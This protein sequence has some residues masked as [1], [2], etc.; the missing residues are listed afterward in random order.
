MMEHYY[1]DNLKS[2]CCDQDYIEEATMNLNSEDI[3]SVRQLLSFRPFL[4]RHDC[5][6]KIKLFE[7]DNFLRD[8][9]CKEMYKLHGYVYS[10]YLCVRLL[11]AFV[12]DMP[13][14]VLGKSVS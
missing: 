1:G 12:K 7:D 13:K 14:N 11:S 6:T 5:S 10:F 2:L 9:L 3:E 4:E 8:A